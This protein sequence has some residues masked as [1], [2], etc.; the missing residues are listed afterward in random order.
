MS[1][2]VL[3]KLTQIAEQ[4]N[5]ILDRLISLH[6]QHRI[7]NRKLQELCTLTKRGW[8]NARE[9]L[10]AVQLSYYNV[11]EAQAYCLDQTEDSLQDLSNTVANSTCNGCI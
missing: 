3:N 1:G 5:K 9:M 8:E 6:D 10:K 2:T 4:Q 11:L 7:S